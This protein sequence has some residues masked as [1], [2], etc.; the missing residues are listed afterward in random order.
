MLRRERHGRGEDALL[1]V[2]RLMEPGGRNVQ[3][4]GVNMQPSSHFSNTDLGL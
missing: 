2:L 4:Y 3:I 1:G